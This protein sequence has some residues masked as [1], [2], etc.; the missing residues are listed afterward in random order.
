MLSLAALDG[1]GFIRFVMRSYGSMFWKPAAFLAN[2]P[3]MEKM[4]CVPEYCEPGLPC[5]GQ[6]LWNGEMVFLTK[7]TQACMPAMAAK[8]AV[9]IKEAY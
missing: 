3:G 7:F 4:A 5:R 2:I 9:I 6:I 8:E 1:V